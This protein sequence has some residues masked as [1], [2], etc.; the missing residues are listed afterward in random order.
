MT[1]V[2]SNTRPY[3]K[4]AL[5][6]LLTSVHSTPLSPKHTNK[7]THTAS[8]QPPNNHHTLTWPAVVGGYK[9]GV[10]R[11]T[12][13]GRVRDAAAQVRHVGRDA[14]HHKPL[15]GKHTQTQMTAAWFVRCGRRQEGRCCC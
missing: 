5:P 11:T 7:Q 14:L 1:L 10:I 2:M 8:Q 13:E 12:P 4:H 3:H 15:R 9:A 6:V